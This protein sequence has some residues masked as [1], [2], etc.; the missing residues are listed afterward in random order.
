MEEVI[1]PAGYER[2]P[3]MVL[4]KMPAVQIGGTRGWLFRQPQ[5]MH[6]DLAK[7]TASLAVIAGWAGSYH[8]RP[9]VLPP[10]VPGPYMVHS[11]AAVPSSAVLTGIIVTSKNFPSSQLHSGT[12]SVDLFFQPDD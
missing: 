4:D 9:D 7:I 5:K 10:L 2:F 12:W 3:F 1:L 8:I 6:L 11:K